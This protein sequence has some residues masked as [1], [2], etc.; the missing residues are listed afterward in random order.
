MDAE[1]GLDFKSHVD[2]IF[3]CFETWLRSIFEFFLRFGNTIKLWYFTQ[4]KQGFEIMWEELKE[5]F[6]N[7]RAF[8]L[9]LGV[10]WK[11]VTRL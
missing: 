2:T 11:V 7:D 10:I 4:Q 8:V 6:A 3:L 1:S 9:L 5:T